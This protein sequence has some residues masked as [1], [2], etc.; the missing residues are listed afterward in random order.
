MGNQCSNNGWVAV[1]TTEAASATKDAT[2]NTQTHILYSFL[3]SFIFRSEAVEKEQMLRTRAMRERDELKMFIK[4]YRFVLLR[5]RMPDGL[6]LQ[7]EER[8]TGRERERE[9]FFC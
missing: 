3:H 7:G 6:I 8:E 4:H 1:T 5:V 2:A 9:Y